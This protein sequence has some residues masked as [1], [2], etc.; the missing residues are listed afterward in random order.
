[1]EE[2]IITRRDF[3]RIT[4]GTAM[5]ATLGSGIPGEAR[6]EPTAKVVLIRHADAV[7]DQGK[8]KVETKKAGDFV[9]VVI[10]NEG[11]RIPGELM[12]RL[13]VPF[14]TSGKDG[15]GLG[16]AVAYQIV[17]E[18]GGEIK[19]KSDDEWSTVFC[20]CLPISSNQD[21]RRTMRDRRSR[22]ADRRKPFA[23]NF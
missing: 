7:S 18:H 3:L 2:K 20:V 8:I 6:A 9:H 14:F 23:D 10:G 21:R 12:D 13:F 5:A 19:V 1:M 16:L 22:M 4:A 15:T 11:E 17:K